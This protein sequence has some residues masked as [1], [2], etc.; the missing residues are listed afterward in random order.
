[1]EISLAL[2]LPRDE[3][4]VPVARRIVDASMRTV[5]VEDACVDDVALALSEACTNVLQHSGPGDE[6][7]VALRLDDAVCSIEVRDLGHGFDFDT[8]DTGAPDTDEERGRGVALMRLLVDRVQFESK[9]ES[10]SV[11]HLEKQLNYA[12]GSLLDRAITGGL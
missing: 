6:Y 5:G 8:L 1:M 4:S 3:L 9:P 12:D 10:G 7:V 2:N 11:V